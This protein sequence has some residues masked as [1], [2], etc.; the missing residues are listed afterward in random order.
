MRSGAGQSVSLGYHCVCRDLGH[1]GWEGD[2]TDAL[3]SLD[4]GHMVPNKDH[5]T[6]ALASLPPSSSSSSSFH[7]SFIRYTSCTTQCL[8]CR[9]W[10]SRAKTSALGLSQ[11]GRGPTSII[12]G[13]GCTK[14][15]MGLGGGR[16]RLP[17]GVRMISEERA[18]GAKR[19]R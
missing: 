16:P 12:S 15:Y 6:A 11:Y 14:G 7:S 17:W 4:K 13:L 1:H 10:G 3:W 8:P 5:P 2:L 18:L 19:Q 9:C